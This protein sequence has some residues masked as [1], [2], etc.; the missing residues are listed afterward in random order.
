MTA[1]S[2]DLEHI[3]ADEA[4][5]AMTAQ[6][7][8]CQP[9][10]EDYERAVTLVR[11]LCRVEEDSAGVV[12]DWQVRSA[13]ILAAI[14]E[15]LGTQRVL[16]HCFKGTLGADWD[17]E[18]AIKLIRRACETGWRPA[19]EGVNPFRGYDLVVHADKRYHYFQVHKPQED[20]R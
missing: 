8:H 18:D 9:S 6:A 13:Q 12:R 4:I 5:E 17:L 1:V 2:A 3:T 14:D 20:P 16:V 11:G 10:G 7:F 19:S 15:G